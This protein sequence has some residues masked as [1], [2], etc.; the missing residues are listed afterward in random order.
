[1][2][3]ARDK[4]LC[5][6]QLFAKSKGLPCAAEYRFHPS[7]KWRFDLAIVPLKIAIEYE[8]IMGAPR[9]R[10]T[11]ATGYTG[12][13]NKYNEAQL[14]GWLVLRFTALNMKSMPDILERAILL[15]NEPK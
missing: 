14:H 15:R 3:K 4:L 12:D 6:C 9:S 1:M 8:G 2:S 10:H 7:R 13:A 11:S 5:K